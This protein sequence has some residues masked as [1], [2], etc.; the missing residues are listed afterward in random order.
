M[1]KEK[2]YSVYEAKGQL[3]VTVPKVLAQA[4]GIEKGGRIKWVIDR[5]ELIL[6]RV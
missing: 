2:T 3:R 1:V 4:I 5:G 6:R